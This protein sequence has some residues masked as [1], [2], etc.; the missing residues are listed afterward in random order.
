LRLIVGLGNPGPTYAKS[1]HNVGFWVVKAI[2]GRAGLAFHRKG[3]SLRASNSVNGTHVVLAKPQ[4]FVNRSGAAVRELIDDLGLD[5]HDLRELIIV[6]DDLDLLPGRLRLK[7]RGGHGG[8]NGVLSII[9]TMN[10]DRFARLKIGIGRPPA[11]CE[12]A[13]FVLAPVPS[14]D[15]TGILEAVDQAVA[16]LDCW[17]SEGLIAAMNRFN[18][19]PLP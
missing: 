6:H 9:D 11:G 14:G 18:R 16:V 7:A 8:H 2:A 5:P 13:D 3:L 17:L 10:T 12:A 4:T 1:R 15:R 19:N